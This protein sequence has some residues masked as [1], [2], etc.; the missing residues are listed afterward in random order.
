MTGLGRFDVVIDLAGSLSLHDL[1]TITTRD[2]TIALVGGIADRGGRLLGPGTQVLAGMLLDR[3]V[4][5]RIVAVRA[6]A[7]ADH[8]AELVTLLDDGTLRV[9]V[10]RTMSFADVPAALAH[11]ERRHTRGKVVITG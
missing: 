5:P 3:L 1:R 7:S 8:L 6:D 10:E 2:G 11:G 9:P 4:A